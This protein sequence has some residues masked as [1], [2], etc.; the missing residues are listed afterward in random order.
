MHEIMDG[1][2]KK[3]L[4]HTKRSSSSAHDHLARFG[5]RT[6]ITVDVNSLPFFEALFS[7]ESVESRCS[8]Y[9]R[10]L[11]CLV[12]SLTLYDRGWSYAHCVVLQPLFEGW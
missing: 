9:P 3:P 5:F 10:S 6:V 2:Q 1:V 7:H 8:K 11:T 12:V 4:S